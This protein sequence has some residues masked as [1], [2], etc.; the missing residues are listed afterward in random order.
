MGCGGGTGGLTTIGGPCEGAGAGTTGTGIG[1]VVAAGGVTAIGVCGAV[2]GGVTG[3]GTGGGGGCWASIRFTPRVV[4]VTKRSVARVIRAS[5]GFAGGVYTRP[6]K[7][8]QG[9]IGVNHRDTENTEKTKTEKKE[10]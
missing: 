10:R 5:L 2:L 7:G 8:V 9:E 4:R 6:L 1:G 3:T